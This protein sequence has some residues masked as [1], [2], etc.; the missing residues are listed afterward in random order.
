MRLQLQKTFGGDERFKLT[1]D[2]DVSLKDA[3]KSKSHISDIMMGQLSKRE[4]EDFMQ[5]KYQGKQR[6][7]KIDTGGYSSLDDSDGGEIQ[8]KHEINLEKERNQALNILSQIVPA[9]EVFLTCSK[10]NNKSSLDQARNSGQKESID[11][12]IGM[13][14]ASGTKKRALHI[15][16]FDPSN[17]QSHALLVKKEDEDTKQKEKG[18]KQIH[19]EGRIH[20]MN[21]RKLNQEM[22]L[23][24]QKKR[25][26]EQFMDNFEQEDDLPED[27]KVIQI[28]SGNWRSIIHKGEKEDKVI[29][30][31]EKDSNGKPQSGGNFFLSFDEK[32]KEEIIYLNEEDKAKQEKKSREAAEKE[33]I[34]LIEEEENLKRKLEL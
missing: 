15:K 1:K 22:S 8:W 6:Q 27:Q 2:F 21:K 5:A 3:N 19:E 18:K 12:L 31:E 4:Q 23:L 26:K 32:P 28:K 17:A 13:G 29:K 14:D 20:I 7:V 24:D 25:L 30:I 16:R 34:E 10:A 11:K 33:T 9:N